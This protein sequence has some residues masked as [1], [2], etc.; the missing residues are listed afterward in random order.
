VVSRRRAIRAWLIGVVVLVAAAAIPPVRHGTLRGAG[1]ALLWNDPVE[2]ADV[3]VISESGSPEEFQAAE[4][5]VADLYARGIIPRVMLLRAAPDRIDEELVRRG[6]HLDNPAIAILR[7]LGVPDA[8]IEVVEAGEGG[9]TESTRTLAAWTRAHPSRVVV[10]I[11]AAHSR[12]Y[13]RALLRVWPENAPPPRVTYPQ[14]TDFRADDWWRGRR[15][16]RDG[17]F[18]LQKLAWDCIRHPW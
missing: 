2:P 11:G 3:I 17:V 9:T 1:G 5:D 15:T 4:I 8:A 6:V 12:R 18:E 10:V 16:L 13:R 7:Q 14:R